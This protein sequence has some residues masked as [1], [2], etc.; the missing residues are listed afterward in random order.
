MRLVAGVTHPKAGFIFYDVVDT[1]KGRKLVETLKT[2]R[3]HCEDNG[4]GWMPILLY[5]YQ[6]DN[7]LNL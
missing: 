2:L 6:T 1:A 5:D 7:S 4:P 3:Q